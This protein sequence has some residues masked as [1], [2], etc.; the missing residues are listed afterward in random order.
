MIDVVAKVGGSLSRGTGLRALCVLLAELGRKHRILVVPG[1]G[2][3]ADTVRECDGRYGLSDA[4]SHWMAVLAM[5]QFGC[6]LSDLIPGSKPAR[7]RDAARQIAL[8]GRVPVFMAFDLLRRTDPLPHG[9][10]VTSDS[11]SAWAAELVG[12]PMLVL[13]KSVDGLTD[14]LGRGA[15]DKRLPGLV[16]LK[17]LAG[18]EGVDPYLATILAGNGLDFWIIDGN[19]PERFKEL[20]ETSTTRG[21]RLQR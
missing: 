8:S 16:T 7:N 18:W 1:G 19:R 17:Q 21:T 2:P 9:W 5:D 4:A 10:A 3:F 6:L 14:C 20:L 15:G 11:I 13:L 12:A